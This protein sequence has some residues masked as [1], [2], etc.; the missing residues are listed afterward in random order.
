MKRVLNP[1]EKK[2][3]R[4]TVSSDD[5]AKFNE[6]VVHNVCSTFALARE[7]EWSTRLFVLEILDPDEEGIGTSLTIDHISPAFENEQVE[8]QVEVKSFDKNEL[9]CSYKALINSRLIAKGDTGQKI[10]KKSRIREI[11]SNFKPK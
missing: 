3:H 10:L 2:V 1:G 11:F 7:I 6:K 4:F 5:V 8:I 9:I